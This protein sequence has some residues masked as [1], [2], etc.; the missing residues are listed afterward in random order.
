M[1]IK[2]AL[3]AILPL[4]QQKAKLSVDKSIKAGNTTDR[5]ANGQT[6]YD[7]NQQQQQHPPM[8]DEQLEKA[9]KHLKE[10]PAIKEHN[11][12]LEVIEHEG[13]RVVLLKEPSGKI[14]R[15][16][17]EAELWTLPVMSQSDP[18]PKG[19]LLRKTA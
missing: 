8:T 15:R 19:Q 9:L 1:D 16:I 3:N 11:L 6:S 5:D 17:P 12:S 18:K 7:Q 14:L 10:F 2:T 13:K 4:S